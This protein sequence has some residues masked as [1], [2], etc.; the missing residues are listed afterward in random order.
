ME[1]RFPSIVIPEGIYLTTGSLLNANTAL[2]VT[3][4]LRRYRWRAELDEQ[5]YTAAQQTEISRVLNVITACRTGKLGSHVFNCAGCQRS[6]IGL[7]KC[8]NRHCTSCGAARRDKW[9]Q[10]MLGWSLD[11]DY[12]HV[13]F[14]LPH[15]PNELLQLN[16]KRLYGVLFRSVSQTLSKTLERQLGFRPGMILTLHTWGQQLNSHVHVHVIIT[17][18]G[19][20]LDG[21]RWIDL[22]RDHPAMRDA[23]LAATFKRTFVR[24]LRHWFRRNELLWP[25]EAEVAQPDEKQEEVEQLEGEDDVQESE[26][27]AMAKPSRSRPCVRELTDNERQLLAK[28]EAKNWMVQCQWP[29]DKHQGPTAIVKYLA[30]YVRGTA[31]GNRRLLDNDGQHVTF[32]YKDYRDNAKVKTLSLPGPEFVQRFCLHILPRGLQRVRYAGLFQARGRDERLE[33]CRQLIAATSDRPARAEES[34]EHSSH[35]HS[36]SDIDID[37]DAEADDLDAEDETLARQGCTCRH[38]KGELTVV[39]RLKGTPTLRLMSVAAA[40][41]SAAPLLAQWWST[42]LLQLLREG[43]RLPSSGIPS[44]VRKL[45]DATAWTLLEIRA[46]VAL[47]E[48]ANSNQLSLLDGDYHVGVPPPAVARVPAA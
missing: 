6:L 15:E 1:D 2:R 36:S 34:Q 5:G 46:L 20:S 25:G 28:I 14:T 21:K 45:V 26:P 41:L 35:P 40:I 11:C 38:C 43:G 27:T 29:P 9:T 33:H 19:L 30:G 48:G 16:P 4:V 7:N 24:R 8:G 3:D 17:A 37:I 39:G 12:L 10:D 13:V 23:A 42:E 47:L 31:I 22:S 32:R 18:G 44:S